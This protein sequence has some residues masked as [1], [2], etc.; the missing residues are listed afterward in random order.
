MSTQKG[1][2]VASHSTKDTQQTNLGS[3]VPR[4][5]R[6]SAIAYTI[7]HRARM[8]I[9]CVIAGVLVFLGTVAAAT[10]FNI[11]H[12]V[13]ERRVNSHFEHQEYLDPNAGQPIRFVLIGQDSRD[14]G[15]ADIAGDGAE[16]AGVHN[17]D[18][19]M[20]VEIAA[21]RQF[22]N[23]VSIPRD[24][25][26]DVPSCT[27]SQGTIPAQYGVMFNSI[28]S[29]AYAVGGDLSSAASC[30]VSAINS[31][32]GLDISNFIVVDFK[33]LAAMIDAIGGVDVCVPVHTVDANTDMDLP[34]GMHH[35]DGKSATNYARMRYGTGTDGSDIMRTTRQQYLIKSLFNE[36]I[37]KNLFTQTSQL[38]Q[39]VRAAI[40][41]LS[42]SE[43]MAD[44]A[45]LVGLAMSLRNMPLDHLYMQT[46]PITAAPTDPNRVV[47]AP[48]ADEVWAKFREDKPL[49]ST[50][51]TTP[52]DTN[53]DGGDTGASDTPSETPSA[54]PSETAGPSQEGTDSPAATPAPTVDPQ[55][56]L[57][58]QP[59]GTLIDPE[60]GGVVDPETGAIKDPDTN[61]YVGI[62]YQ[63][64]NNT[65]CAVPATKQ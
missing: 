57:I 50:E 54:S 37:S 7:R 30:T 4:R 45:A 23:L 63:Y 38:Y 52:S 16:N 6:H 46:V 2:P 35:L 56:G 42:I 53:E 28:F 3:A 22:I 48:D 21:D 34:K 64:L 60:T 17:A 51:D 44:T 41:S 29:T 8:V 47:W 1:E 61:Q 24:S 58:K 10:W 36:A 43:G 32:T 15:N 20:V 12:A 31:L 59:D 11:D 39:L 26:V 65:V 40:N 55:T 5:P 18:T 9:A 33:G 62:A 49:F 14:A 27:T 25:L 13:Q 19:T